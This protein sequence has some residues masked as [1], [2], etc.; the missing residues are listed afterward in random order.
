MELL[1]GA[2]VRYASVIF[3]QLPLCLVHW[4]IG[5]ARD[6]IDDVDHA[7]HSRA[8]RVRCLLLWWR[9]WRWLGVMRLMVDGWV[10]PR[11]YKYRR[12]LRV[13]GWGR[14]QLR[15]RRSVRLRWVEH[16]RGRRRLE[17]LVVIWWRQS[18]ELPR[19]L[20]LHDVIHS[21]ARCFPLQLLL[22]RRRALMGVVVSVNPMEPI[23]KPFTAPRCDGFCCC[24]FGPLPFLCPLL[25][26]PPFRFWFW[27]GV[28]IHC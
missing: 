13:H 26:P 3:L 25:C 28:Q 23:E 21:Q 7:H 1:H 11:R 18:P 8:A 24:G 16:L 9:W 4:L 17:R 15:R 14:R 12:L 2:N 6:R 27:S 20:A 5:A 10:R 22:D 19:I